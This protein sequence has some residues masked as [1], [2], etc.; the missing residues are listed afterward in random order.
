MKIA[1]IAITIALALTATAAQAQQY[2]APVVQQY[3]EAAATAT[4]L[5]QDHLVVT[6]DYGPRPTVTATYRGHTVTMDAN[7]SAI[8]ICQVKSDDIHCPEPHRHALP[9]FD[10][11]SGVYQIGGNVTPPSWFYK[12]EPQFS[13]EAR[14]AKIGGNVLVYM[15]VDANGQP[16]NVRVLQGLGH[17]LDEKAVE[18]MQA[19]TFHPA[20]KNGVPVPVE[21]QVEV[22][23]AIH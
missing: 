4:V 10:H 2:P 1:T 14:Q 11:M 23:F 22:N 6:Y 5:P 9:A 13:E 17:G 7:N 20:M 18:A 3:P 8:A 16:R 15:I 12:Q 21:L 19:S